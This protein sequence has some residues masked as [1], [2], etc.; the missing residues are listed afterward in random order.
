MGTIQYSGLRSRTYNSISNNFNILI[1]AGINKVILIGNLGKDPEV[2]TTPNGNNVCNF[3]L[4]T[5]EKYKDKAGEIIENTE[6]HNIVLWN[7]LADLA[8]KYLTK[9]SQIYLEGKI[10]TRSYEV[11]GVKKYVTEIYGYKMTF[12]GGKQSDQQ[13]PID[14]VEP[15]ETA[16]DEPNDL[17][18]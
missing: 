13:K 3:S 9:G 5:S 17:P 8:G 11:D 14:R 18:F 4:A 15:A 2:K 1:M 16:K 12:L 10:K 6:W 7:Q